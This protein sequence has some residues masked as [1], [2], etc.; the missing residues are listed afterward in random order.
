[1]EYEHN[2]HIQV[3]EDFD[4][5]FDPIPGLVEIILPRFVAFSLFRILLIQLTHESLYVEFLQSRYR[6]ADSNFVIVP[7]TTKL[8]TA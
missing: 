1:M 7:A 3:T 6:I 2:V 5:F 4:D 8:L